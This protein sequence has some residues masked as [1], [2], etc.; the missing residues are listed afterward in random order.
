MAKIKLTRYIDLASLRSVEN[1]PL[2]FSGVNRLL[3]I[4]GIKIVEVTET[5]GRKNKT[6][7]VQYLICTIYGW[8]DKGE[9][10]GTYDD[11]VTERYLEAYDVLQLRKNYISFKKQWDAMHAKFTALNNPLQTLENAVNGVED[12]LSEEV[13]LEIARCIREDRKL[14]AMKLY[15]TATGKSL[16]ET[17]EYIKQ[18]SQ[19]I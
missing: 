15:K 1:K 14:L 11:E 12:E 17:K 13:A 6:R 19:T 4:T 3:M 7:N 2:M 5:Y 8:N 18:L 9:F 16:E 10:V